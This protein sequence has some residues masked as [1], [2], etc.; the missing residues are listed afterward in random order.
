MMIT[1]FACR[2]RHLAWLLLA[3]ATLAGCSRPTRVEGAWAEG[4]A[5]GQSFAAVLVV[6]VSP[7]YNTRCRFE[8]MMMD[9][10]VSA[11]VRA[12]TSCSQMRSDE[13]LTREAVVRAVQAL[14]ADAVLSTRLVD[15]RVGVKEGGSSETRSEAYYKPIGYGYDSYYGAFGLPVT[16]V[17]FTNEQSAFTVQRTAVVSSNL[18]A[19][20]D[21]SLVYVV[22]STAYDKDSQG[23]VIDDITAGI[24]RELQRAGVLA[25]RR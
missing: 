6:G 15:G 4:A 5:R 24:A 11:G 9:S 10:L 7:A 17:D 25:A 1:N 14:G 3:A 19:V 18:Y 21:A 20:H 22:D 2:W 8:R 16:Y 23:A 13:P 12:M